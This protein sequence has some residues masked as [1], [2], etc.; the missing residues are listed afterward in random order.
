MLYKIENTDDKKRILSPLPFLEMSDINKIE[1]DLENL[2]A[3]HLLDVLF[4]DAVLMPIFQERSYQSEA[5]LYALNQYGDLIIFELKRS[6]VG[7]DAMHQILGYSQ[8]AGQWTFAELQEKYTTYRGSELAQPANL[9]DAHKEAFQ[10]KDAL[11]PIQFNTKQYLMVIGSA[12]NNDLINAIDY[13]KKKGLSVEFIPYRIYKIGTEQYFEFFSIPYDKHQNP[14]SIKGVLFDTN[15]SYDEESIWQMMEKSRVAAY[16]D[17]KYVIDYINPRDIV[18]FSHKGYGVVAAAEVA[19]RRKSDPNT[20][21]DEDEWYREVK[22]LT[23][24]PTRNDGVI[25]YMPFS[26]VAEVTGKSFY[27]ARTI[28][29]P[30]LSR[31]ESKALLIE[32]KKVL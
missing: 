23:P 32:L 29:V 17:I 10:L 21:N 9:L 15:K 5:D 16:G 24:K 13:W 11:Q 1:K 3:D 30:Y 12:A 26:R 19:S 4:E 20:D 8:A 25:K 31:D 28:K 27:W 7:A 2:L 18:F 6:N 22:F 14:M